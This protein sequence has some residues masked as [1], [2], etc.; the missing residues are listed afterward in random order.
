MLHI[1]CIFTLIVEKL[2]SNF[3]KDG[4]ESR[5]KSYHEEFVFDPEIYEVGNTTYNF[6]ILKKYTNSIVAA[7]NKNCFD[8]DF[9]HGIAF[10][11]LESENMTDE[12]IIIDFDQLTE[13]LV[14]FI[15]ALNDTS[16]TINDRME[17]ALQKDRN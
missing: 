12:H 6:D 5:Q 15:N 1:T 9:L 14:D 17:V 16:G 3:L 4:C 13:D 7:S 2:K 10:K 8:S 11:I